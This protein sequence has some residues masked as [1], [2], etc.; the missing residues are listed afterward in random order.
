MIDPVGPRL[1]V[2]VPAYNEEKFLGPLLASLDAARA[3]LKAERG[4]EAEIIVVDNG[5]TDRT[6]EV[7]RAAG[8][9][10]VAESKRQI[11]ASRNA[12]VRAARGTVVVTCDAD[13]R[14]SDN[15]LV[16]VDEEM[17]RGDCV[18]GGVRIVPEE[19]R[20]NTDLL[21]AVFD[22]GARLFGVGFGVLFT[23]RA[24]FDRIG[25]FPET[26]YVGED[27]FFVL[28]LRKEGRR[29][30]KRFARVADAHI[31]TSLRKIDEF[32]FV[33]VLWQHFKFVLMPWRLRQRSAAP[34]WYEV[35]KR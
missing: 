2:V 5:S 13:N 29:L 20:W 10:V 22:W 8:A 31:R 3:R 25:G 18:G 28:A 26:V 19:S 32:G 6:A 7:A 35:R 30:K 16:R 9:R 12:G 34:T 4:V 14:V 11:A 24:T 17:A 33:N 21:F 23:D 27:G 1:S 15:L